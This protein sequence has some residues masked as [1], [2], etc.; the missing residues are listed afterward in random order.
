ML[1]GEEGVKKDKDRSIIYIAAELS[2]PSEYSSKG[3]YTEENLLI[4]F[5]SMLLIKFFSF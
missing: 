2:A 5:S 3:Q 4:K 1:G